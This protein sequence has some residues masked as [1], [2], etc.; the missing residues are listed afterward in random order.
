MNNSLGTLPTVTLHTSKTEALPDQ[1]KVYFLKTSPTEANQV[2]VGSQVL[3][4]RNPNESFQDN[5]FQPVNQTLPSSTLFSP[6]NQGV[7]NIIQPL[8]NDQM[9]Q[10]S[11]MN[12]SRSQTVTHAN[13]NPHGNKQVPGNSQYKETIPGGPPFVMSQNF[14]TQGPVVV[15]SNPAQQV[16]QSNDD[17]PVVQVYTNNNFSN[18]YQSN[19]KRNS[20]H[21]Q[22]QASQSVPNRQQ[23]TN[24][25]QPITMNTPN[26]NDNRQW[27]QRPK[28][29]AVVTHAYRDIQKVHSNIDHNIK[30]AAPNH[31][32]VQIL[33]GKQMNQVNPIF[34][35]QEQNQQ[36]PGNQSQ[37]GQTIEVDAIN[38]KIEGENE[39]IE[40][41]DVAEDSIPH[42]QQV[43]GS[44]VLCGK[45][46]LYLC[47]T[48]KRVWYC[49]PA[50]Q[51]RI[52]VKLIEARRVILTI[53]ACCNGLLSLV[54]GFICRCFFFILLRY[55]C[56]LDSIIKLFC[57]QSFQLVNLVFFG[58]SLAMSWVLYFLAQIVLHYYINLFDKLCRDFVHRLK[59]CMLFGH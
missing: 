42:L 52:V 40:I 33:P 51:V 22:D 50:C 43:H 54:W 53:I 20:V 7:S 3:Q 11:E 36:L 16:Q 32:Q 2:P 28:Q 15:T 45:F 23:P 29:Q 59:M 58:I 39:C 34:V 10:M 1:R 19:A 26:D 48:C 27:I 57:F 31:N 47:S 13:I 30:Q 56:G 38:R 46:S 12:Q 35:D 4:N 5:H 6:R 8:Q 18:A 14:Q 37:H 41:V 24:Q 9:M 17:L 55:G 21:I 49:S 44:C 25:S